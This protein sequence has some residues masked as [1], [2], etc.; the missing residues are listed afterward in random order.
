ML[1]G[2]SSIRFQ[3]DTLSDGS[4]NNINVFSH[5]GR[6]IVT[7]DHSFQSSYGLT[8]YVFPQHGNAYYTI[9]DL[10]PSDVTN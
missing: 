7:D 2:L 9:M 6:K 3:Q 8:K 4:R 10:L 5:N 1:E